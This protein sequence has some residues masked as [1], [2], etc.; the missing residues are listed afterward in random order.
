MSRY[1][2]LSS[3]IL[4]FTLSIGALIYG[5]H[6][7]KK[8]QINCQG[9]RF[10]MVSWLQPATIPQ[11]STLSGYSYNANNPSEDRWIIQQD[12]PRGWSI[13]CVLD[14]HGG[15]QV[16]EFVSQ[17]IIQLIH[18]RILSHLITLDQYSVE[19]K[20]I[21]IFKDLE[22]SYIQS[23]RSTYKLGYGEVAKVGSCALVAFKHDDRLTIANCG[24]CRA[25]I[26]TVSANNDRYYATRITMDHNC[27]EPIEEFQ[28]QQAHPNESDVVICK[29][30]HACY[31]K[32]RL[33]LTRALGDIYL[34][35][36]EFNSPP[37]SQSRGRYIPEPYTPPYVLHRPDIYHLKLDPSDKFVI[38]ATDGVWDFL[39]DEQ[40]V[41]IVKS[42]ASAAEAS[43]AIVEAV[44]QTAASEIQMT[45]DELKSLPA[46]SK[47]RSKHDDTT[48]VVIYF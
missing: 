33:Q 42:S 14:G 6:S 47:R 19:E 18:D 20:L 13:G 10:N 31:V 15:W 27:R 32:G 21:Q 36:R 48:A 41:N 43:Q 44:L 11:S 3:P 1:I 40:A 8:Y 9:S 38:L 39:S 26:G 24:D 2:R 7:S 45:V 28:L 25:V 35:Y 29:N 12:I 16:S 22:L 23:V 17:R 34:K 4:P 37:S 5:Y 46:G 30:S